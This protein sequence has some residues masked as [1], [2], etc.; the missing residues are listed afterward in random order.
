MNIKLSKRLQTIG[1]MVKHNNLYDIGS[2][3][4]LLP[5]YLVLQGRVDF[6]IATDI[7]AKP[8]ERGR[9]NAV[10][11]GVADKIDFVLASGLT[12]VKTCDLSRSTCV[13]AGMGGEAI[14][15]II[16]DEINTARKFG[17]LILS[18]QRDIACVRKFLDEH[19]FIITDEVM[20][21][22]ADKFYNILNC[23]PKAATASTGHSPAPP[24]TYRFGRHLI[25]RACPIFRQYLEAEIAKFEC[26]GQKEHMDYIRQC[27]EVLKC[28]K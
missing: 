3:H 1:D 23:M 8:L 17:Q 26:F 22:E 25:E 19:G 24:D 11:S 6:A 12:A 15:R 18:P 20:V 9:A 2:D 13:I 5:V 4:A 28:I 27:K 16:T 7:A 14:I 21:F 10:K